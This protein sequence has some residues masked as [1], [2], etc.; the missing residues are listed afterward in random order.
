ML[1][2]SFE[3]AHP[4]YDAK[5]LPTLPGRPDILAM[6]THGQKKERPHFPSLAELEQ[7]RAKRQR[8]EQRLQEDEQRWEE[9]LQAGLLRGDQRLQEEKQRWEA[10]L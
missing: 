4:L 2:T 3:D 7:E 1:A 10:R 8:W 9:R 6:H 5:K